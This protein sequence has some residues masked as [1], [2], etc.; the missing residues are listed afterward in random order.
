MLGLLLGADELAIGTLQIALDRIVFEVIDGLGFVGGVGVVASAASGR[1]GRGPPTFGGRIRR[2]RPAGYTGQRQSR[3]AANEGQTDDESF[4]IS[5]LLHLARA[6]LLG[7]RQLK[8]PLVPNILLGTPKDHRKTGQMRSA[9]RFIRAISSSS[10]FS[11]RR[12][13]PRGLR[14]RRRS[15]RS[16]RHLPRWASSD[17][18]SRRRARRLCRLRPYLRHPWRQQRRPRRPPASSSALPSASAVL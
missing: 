5:C 2:Q 6:R 3:D 8:A 17:R 7:I 9:L 10:S 16:R 12:R 15:G 18:S 11:G 1:G 13:R 4:H 14:P